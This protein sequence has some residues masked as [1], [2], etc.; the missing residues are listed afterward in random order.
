MR[1][2]VRRMSYH[3]S[4]ILG[5]DSNLGVIGRFCVCDI[6]YVCVCM[7]D[8]SCL[9]VRVWVQSCVRYISV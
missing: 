7:C 4:D 9:C 1:V 5:G 3:Y 6:V 2:C 8:R